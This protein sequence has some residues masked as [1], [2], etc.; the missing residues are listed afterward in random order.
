MERVVIIGGGASGLV[1]A[2]YAAKQGNK[3]TILERNSCCGKKILLTGNGRCNYWNSNQCVEHY[4]SNNNDFLSK[5]I[6]DNNKEEI[7][8]FFDSIGIVPKIEKGYYYPFSNQAVS[9][10]QTLILQAQLCGVEIKNNFFVESVIKR[11]E[12]FIIHSK[13]EK[14][15]ADKVVLATGSKALPKTGSDGS[16]YGLAKAFGHSITSVLPALTQLRG[17][18]PY[19]KKWNGIR[20]DV[21]ITL[22]EDGNLIKEET[23]QIQL[24]DYGI[25]GICVFNLSRYVAQGLYNHQK[26]YVTINFLPWLKTKKQVLTFLE[27]QNKLVKKCT[28]CQLLEGILNYKL[29]NVLLKKANININKTWNHLNQNEKKALINNLYQFHLD[30][31]DTNSFD[32]AQVCSGG[33]P[34]SEINLKTMESLKTKGLY[35]VG[36]LLDVDGDCGGYNLSFAWISGMLAGVSIKE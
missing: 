34:L 18:E 16:G 29:V 30:I 33:I 10:Q 11:N 5:I 32:K 19:F 15:I 12:E 28:I 36:E 31:I 7:L 27:D 26:E 14:I 24:T 9:I 35:L 6:T 22:Y 2:I 21:N 3:V 25:S 13:I 23:G 4:H 8:S 1:A 20:T 17:K